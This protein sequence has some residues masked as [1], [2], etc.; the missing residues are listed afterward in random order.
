[1]SGVWGQGARVLVRGVRGRVRERVGLEGVLVIQV[2][3][4]LV[5]GRGRG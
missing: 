5:R 4:H 2:D 1:M 3:V